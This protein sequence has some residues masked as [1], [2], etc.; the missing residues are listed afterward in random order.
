ME[1]ST[2]NLQADSYQGELSIPLDV[3]ALNPSI[4]AAKAKAPNSLEICSRPLGDEAS[5]IMAEGHEL[6]P[7][8]I[9]LSRARTL[10]MHAIITLGQIYKYSWD[11]ENSF[12]FWSHPAM[13]VAVTG[14]TIRSADGSKE[15]T[16][17]DD[18]LVQATVNPNGVNYALLKD[19]RKAYSCR[20]WIFSPRA[21][22]LL[23]R[24]NAVQHAV[25]EE[26]KSLYEWLEKN[27][28]LADISDVAVEKRI[29]TETREA[30]HVTYGMLSLASILVS[31]VFAKWRFRFF[32]EGQ[33]NC[34][35]FIAELMEKANYAFP[36]DIHAFPCDIAEQLYAELQNHKVMQE[37]ELSNEK[38]GASKG[39][40]QG[41]AQLR[42]QISDDR[43]V[44]LKN[45]NT[46]RMS[47]RA[48]K[49]LLI[50]LAIA[51]CFAWAIAAWIWPHIHAW[52][53]FIRVALAGFFVY[54]IAVAAPITYYAG[55]AFLNVAFK[56]IPQLIVMLRPLYWRRLGDLD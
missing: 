2:R 29:A 21:F 40:I 19:F 12:R 7:G 1:V 48:L 30:K 5:P 4:A 27:Q 25:S 46:F 51:G 6:Q 53:W 39:W 32:N 55:R 35:S 33:A 11:T 15:A 13:I 44:M 49:A 45:A 52:P 9:V 16:V 20:C 42:K 43:K 38:K 14:Q 34:A 37:T 10:S 56:G 24:E 54:A 36:S 18:V 22:E 28:L 50:M 47:G 17:T 8:D 23:E 3:S 26:G 41:V 31:Q